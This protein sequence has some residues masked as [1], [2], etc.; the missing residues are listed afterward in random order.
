MTPLTQDSMPKAIPQMGECKD[1]QEMLTRIRQMA[2]LL[3]TPVDYFPLVQ[4]GDAQPPIL[5]T[6]SQS[7]RSTPLGG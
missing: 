1:A 7:C 4:S 5:Y 3:S 6:I 2:P